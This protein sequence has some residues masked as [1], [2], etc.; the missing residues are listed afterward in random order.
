MW[1][2]STECL[3]QKK[4]LI[5]G[6][7][8]QTTQRGE[9]R[10]PAEQP[11]EARPP[12][13]LPAKQPSEARLLTYLPTKQLN[14]TTTGRPRSKFNIVFNRLFDLTTA[15]L[16]STTLI[17][18]GIPYFILLYEDRRY[19]TSIDLHLLHRC[20]YLKLVS[21]K[22]SSSCPPSNTARRGYRPTCPPSNPARR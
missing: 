15:P 14:K 2:E 11:S 10:L 18:R 13:N 19:R 22:L 21:H 8:D 7:A 3:V 1:I 20:Y 12:T 9:A 5:L 17:C 16:A 6:V 4:G